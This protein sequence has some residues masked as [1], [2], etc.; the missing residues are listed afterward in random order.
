LQP[1]QRLQKARDPSA[2]LHERGSGGGAQQRNPGDPWDIVPSLRRVWDPTLLHTPGR[3]KRGE[4][5]PL[6]AIP[7]STRCLQKQNVLLKEVLKELY[8]SLA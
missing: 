1:G 3:G 7:K 6:N 8:Y 2:S 5:T 4:K